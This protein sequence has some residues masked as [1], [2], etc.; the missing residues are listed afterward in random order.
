MKEKV[1]EIIKKLFDN[2]R[3]VLFLLFALE[4]ILTIFITPSTYDDAWFI[5]QVTDELNVETNEIIEHTIPDFLKDRYNNWSSRIIIEFVLCLVL[6]TSKYLWILI[7]SLMVVLACYSLSRIFVKEN[8]TKN[9]F[10]LL[11]MILIYPYYTMHQT[12]WASTSI[13]YLWPLATGLFCLVPIKKIWDGEKIR[14]FE[15]PL[16]LISLLFA[17]NQEQ[18]GAVILGFYLI[19]TILMILRKDKKVNVFMFIQTILALASV[20]FILTCPGNAIRQVEELHRFK[21]YEMLSF[22]DKFVLG[23]TATFGRIIALQNPVYIL[24]TSL[25]AVYV[26]LNYKEKLY[27]VVALIPIITVLLLGPLLPILNGIFPYLNVFKDSIMTENVLMTAVNCNNIYYAFPMIFAFAN[28]ICIGM[29]ILL[30]FKNLE[31]NIAI[32][33]YLAG[34]ASRVILGFSPTVFISKTRTMIFFDFAMIAISYLVWE[35]L[36]KKKKASS[37]KTL[38]VINLVIKYS[39]IIQFANVLIYIYS[40]QVLY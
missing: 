22:I 28:F 16:Y 10:M 1:K 36:S 7:Q 14:W 34:L 39:A 35:K 37:E 30:I 23:F 6:K 3:G 17:A 25:I 15:Y 12:G 2:G 40:R 38:K 27:R 21:G 24:M 33:I 11:Y 26:V 18:A 19:F 9:N 8:K 5:Q 13:N 4:I 31:K 32:L 29:S 20:I